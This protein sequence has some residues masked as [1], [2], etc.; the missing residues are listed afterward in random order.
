MAEVNNNSG[1][2][3]LIAKYGTDQAK[4]SAGI[5]SS[6]A[7]GDKASVGDQ[8]VFLKLYIEQLKG[9]DPTAPQDT[10]DMV[11][12]MSQFS[13]LEQLTSI[14][15]QLESMTAALT[16]SQALGASTLVG[17]SVFVTQSSAQLTQGETLDMRA[18]IPEDASE[19]TMKVYN[20]SGE[21]VRTDSWP[22]SDYLWD[23]KDDSGNNLPTG[24]YRFEVSARNLEGEVTQL[25]TLL[26]ARIQ[27]VTINGPSGTELNVAGHGKISLTDELEIIG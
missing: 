23:G 1:L 10:N 18:T 21:L 2:Q 6:S 27:G 16:S 7:T 20:E 17:K 5:E 22:S 8:D 26:P 9:Q 4:A 13:S 15:T 14:S 24:K 3:A 19:V 12:Q 11:A 25:S